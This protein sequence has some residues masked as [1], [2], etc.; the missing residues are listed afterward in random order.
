MNKILENQRPNMFLWVPFLMAFGAALYFSY[1]PEPNLIFCCVMAV[2]TFCAAAF[3]RAPVIVRGILLFIFGFCY[4]C[5]YTN[6]LNTPIMPRNIT[7]KKL[8]GRVIALDHT[9]DKHRIFIRLSNSD[10]NIKSDGSAIVRVS[11]DSD[12]LPDLGDKISTR[13]TLFKPNPPDI[14]GGF[15]FARWA[16][17][18]GLTAT[19]Y[20][21]DFTIMAPGTHTT[22]NGIRDWL[23]IKSNSR[24]VD[25]LVLG[26]KNTLPQNERATWMSAGVGH[27]WS[28]SGFHMTLIGGWLFTLFYFIFRCTPSIVRR[29]PAR[30]IAAILAWIGIL[31]YLCVSGMGVATIRAFFMTTLLLIAAIMGRNAFSLRNVCL[32]FC[33]IFLINPYYV[34]TAGFQ[35]S[36]SAIFGLV[37][38]WTVINP[39]MPENKILRILY[40]AVLTATI[41]SLFTAP[42]VALH[43]YSV[44]LYSIL[45]NLILLPI[46]SFLIMPLVMIGVIFAIFG[47]LFPLHIADMIYNWTFGIANYIAEL[48]FAKIT[49]AYISNNA[50]C[51][52]ILGM[53]CIVF[54][55]TIKIK[56]N[57][58]LG[59]FFILIGTTVV[60]TSSRPVFFA[61]PDHE[62][63]GVANNGELL[64]N[65][66]HDS[67]HFFAFE[68]WKH[69]TATNLDTPNNRAKHDHGLYI[70]ETPKYKIAYTQ[71]FV[72]LQ[73]NLE[74]LCN[75]DNIDFIVSYLNITG[76]KC[77]DKIINGGFTIYESGKIIYVPINRRW[78]NPH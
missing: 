63:V 54:I 22:M 31:V 12:I 21:D 44:P 35:L 36:F 49:P 64:F 19:G 75:D 59:A 46:F 34:M 66:S 23:H 68:T 58:I 29:I 67:G 8:V 62:L 57:Y 40:T 38:F 73:N 26:Y 70:F 71:K 56:T 39:K 47:V 60:A 78:N 11:I 61:T 15:D 30:H 55:R 2:I 5:M 43:F 50:I 72:A 10:L 6:I 52:I 28:I 41:A 18:S 1:G 17:F 20:I 42:F 32:A 45:G 13:A 74:R 25:G 76:D 48:P 16:Y 69:L 9:A 24:L 4:A 37:W 7:N 27:I 51:F 33:A 77:R 53:M 14:R 65:K 3:L